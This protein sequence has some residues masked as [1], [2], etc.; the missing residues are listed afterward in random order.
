MIIPGIAGRRSR[1]SC[2]ECVRNGAR[3]AGMPVKSSCG[4]RMR[5]NIL[6]VPALQIEPRPRRQKFETGLRQPEAALAG[7]HGIEA[8]AQRMQMQDIGSCIGQLRLAE[9][10][11]TPVARL[12]LL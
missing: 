1:T 2:Q 6:G 9:A 8:L 4:S 7:E 3:P 5:E 11:R 10:L 12:L